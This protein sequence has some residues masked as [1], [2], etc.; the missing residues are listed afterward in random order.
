MFCTNCGKK[1]EDI[2]KFCT[3]CGTP[4]RLVQQ[5]MPAAQTSIQGTPSEQPLQPEEL[6][7]QPVQQESA[8]EQPLQP[9]EMYRQPMQ[10]EVAPEQPLQPEEQYRQPVQQELTPEQP[11]QPEEMFHQPVQ[12]EAAPEQFNQQGV[13]PTQT[14][15]QRVQAPYPQAPQPFPQ[16]M[17]QPGSAPVKKSKKKLI[18]IVSICVVILIAGSG[19]GYF[20]YQNHIKK[21]AKNVIAYY[22][23][24][25]Y[26]KAIDLYEKFSGKQKD[27]DET[28][29]KELVEKAELIKEDYLL[30]K[31][32]YATAE[33][34]LHRLEEYGIDDLEEA[35]EDITRFVDKIYLSR[36]SYKN[37]KM[38]FEAGDYSSAILNYSSVIKED[39]V[40]YDLALK[41][42]DRARKE[43]ELKQQEEHL[44]AIREQALLDAEYYASILEYA[45]AIEEIEQGLLEIPGDQA[46]T[47]QLAAYKLMQELT[48]KVSSIFSTRY[49]QTYSYLEENYM[50]VAMA[51]PVLEG[52]NPAYASINET[53]DRIKNDYISYSESM[54]ATAK[55][56]ASDEY[57]Y[58]Y[59]FD[60]DFTVTY[61]QNGILCILLQGYEY[62]GGAHGYPIRHVLTF[63]L[64]TGWQLE[65]SNLMATDDS[66]FGSYVIT[67]FERM[68][69]QGDVMYWDDA[70]QTVEYNAMS[71]Y[72]LN[73]Y[74]AEDEIR[75]F[76]YPYD[77]ASYADGFI[78]IAVPY[79]GNEWMFSFLK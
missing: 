31:I 70:L 48:Q 63:D 69:N 42:I 76:Y 24:G 79:A 16:G 58:A 33:E 23:D 19:A 5:A 74:L 46:L 7:R 50:T 36:E 1:L 11:L 35:I 60:M 25:A 43:E 30:E 67:E 55:E 37:G 66:T 72:T 75:I 18:L 71:F 12:Q 56:Y 78:E 22:D 34:L 52:D 21:Q 51:F 4:T 45:S 61:N 15:Q 26:D 28:V 40:Y 44:I 73:Y 27:F 14:Y 64:T 47:D 29:A 77:L 17:E 10:Q 6:F 41:E 68:Y 38:F 65:L 62:T 54:A 8:P 9:E 32:D 49:D 2:A 13:I 53:I 20:F 59:S 39:K 57:F 3:G